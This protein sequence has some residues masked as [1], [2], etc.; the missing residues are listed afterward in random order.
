L[1]TKFLFYEE[2]LIRIKK[3]LDKKIK[4]LYDNRVADFYSFF[5]KTEDFRAIAKR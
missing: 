5:K 1:K 4:T 3:S 2:N